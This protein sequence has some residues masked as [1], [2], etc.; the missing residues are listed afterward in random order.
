MADI[1][2][3]IKEFLDDLATDPMEE[4]VVEYV[5][6][7]VT[8]GRRLIEIMDDPYVKNRLNEDKRAA[9]FENPEIVDAVEAEIRVSFSGRELDFSS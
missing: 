3:G 7:E 1:V 9:V 5:I 6:R 2:K 8:S 4:R